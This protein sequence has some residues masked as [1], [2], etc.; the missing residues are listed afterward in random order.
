MAYEFLNLRFMSR[1]LAVL[2]GELHKMHTTPG[3]EIML[4]VHWRP[5]S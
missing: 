3:V 1:E 2:L 4:Q 5:C